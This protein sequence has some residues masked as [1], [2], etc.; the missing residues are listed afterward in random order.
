MGHFHGTGP[1]IELY[2]W[3]PSKWNRQSEMNNYV[4]NIIITY[5]EIKRYDWRGSHPKFAVHYMQMNEWMNEWNVKKRK[6]SKSKT[7]IL[8]DKGHRPILILVW[9]ANEMSSCSRQ[10]VVLV[11][12]WV[13]KLSIVHEFIYL[14]AISNNHMQKKWRI[15]LSLSNFTQFS[16]LDWNFT[17]HNWKHSLRKKPIWLAVFIK[18]SC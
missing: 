1:R 9:N 4:I 18:W 15:I 12:M 8:L 16:R 5:D 13:F 6:I 17:C 3:T 7:N 2:Y 10:T 11:W 14:N